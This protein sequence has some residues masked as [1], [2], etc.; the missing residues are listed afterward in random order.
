MTVEDK[1]KRAMDLIQTLMSGTEW[2]A[3]TLDAIAEVVRDTGREVLE[4]G[5]LEA[6]IAACD[7]CQWSLADHNRLCADHIEMARDQD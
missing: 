3:D 2:D 6:E 4:Y 1:D 5:P 7:R